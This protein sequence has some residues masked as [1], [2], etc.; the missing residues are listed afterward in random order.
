[1]T[2]SATSCYA[3]YHE[4]DVNATCLR[5]LSDDL[6][7]MI[8]IYSTEEGM[9]FQEHFFFDKGDVAIDECYSVHAESFDKLKM[10]EKNYKEKIL[11]YLSES[12]EFTGLTK[13][14]VNNIDY[15]DAIS[16]KWYYFDGISDENCEYP[17]TI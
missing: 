12:Y 15:G 8:E 4:K 7:L 16:G 14:I 1:M 6:N 3:D 5:H 17:W 10:N 9:G 11:E 13:E 2:D